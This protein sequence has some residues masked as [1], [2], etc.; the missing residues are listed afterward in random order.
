[1]TAF[2]ARPYL[3][4]RKHTPRYCTFQIWASCEYEYLDHR[5]RELENNP[6]TTNRYT[7]TTT[8]GTL[9]YFFKD[10]MGRIESTYGA[11]LLETTKFGYNFIIIPSGA[12]SRTTTRETQTILKTQQ[13]YNL[14][15]MIIL[16]LGMQVLV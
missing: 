7:I 14:K 12:A 15:M 2:V 6:V 8:A 13:Y 3:M 5:T 4:A 11:I 9:Q 16:V 1:M 10:C